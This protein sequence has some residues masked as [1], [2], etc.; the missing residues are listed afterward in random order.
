[1]RE[2]KQFLKFEVTVLAAPIILWKILVDP[3]LTSIVIAHPTKKIKIY[4]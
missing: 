1:M 4:D 3:I 2:F